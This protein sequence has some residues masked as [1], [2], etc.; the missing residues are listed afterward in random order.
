MNA[1]VR[2]LDGLDYRLIDLAVQLAPAYERNRWHREL[3]S[4]LDDMHAERIST[5]RFALTILLG[6]GRMWWPAS[7]VLATVTPS[8]LACM[9]ILGVGGVL[10]LLGIDDMLGEELI[11]V[12]FF[13]DVIAVLALLSRF[14]DQERRCQCDECVL[15][16]A[17]RKSNTRWYQPPEPLIARIRWLEPLAEVER[18]AAPKDV[19]ILFWRH[20]L[21][22]AYEDA[23]LKDETIALRE[24]IA[25]DSERIHSADH[26]RTLASRNNLARSY[27][28]A[29][30]TADAIS[31][32]ERTLIDSERILGARHPDTVKSRENLA[33][34]RALQ[35]RLQ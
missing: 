17:R 32:Y 30:R 18:L 24:Q 28:S 34:V 22:Q 9:A 11:M 16:T 12:W 2:R 5:A 14:E 23:G 7:R 10:V 31:L 29:G 27:R 19:G 15:R 21:A 8:P 33:R 20:Q 1:F 35:K 3:H 25:T 6:A 26:P 13:I 4:T